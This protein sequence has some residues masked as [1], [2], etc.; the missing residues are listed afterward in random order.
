MSANLIALSSI[1]RP[2]QPTPWTALNDGIVI[3]KDILELLSSSMYVDPMS[4]YREYVQN[5]ADSTDQARAL[6]V[7]D[8]RAAARVEIE[9][10]ASKRSIRIRD[11]GLGV[12][13]AEF[14]QRLVAFGASTKR[15]QRA[16]GFRGVGRLAGL[17]YC[18][19]L[20]FRG[21]SQGDPIVFEMLWDCRK[22]RALL[23]AADSNHHLREV[24]MQTVSTR[25]VET[26]RVP[27]HFFE[28]EMCGV[29]RH[30]N[31]QLLDPDAVTSYLSQVAPVPF[32]PEFS[33][34]DDIC[35]TLKAYVKLGE[36]RIAI[37][38]AE[39]PVYRPHR[40]TIP[41]SAGVEERFQAWEPVSV[42][43]QDGGM[44]AIGWV[45]HHSY[46]G[47]LASATGIKGLRVRC[48]NIQVGDDRV[49][50]EL[51]LE[52]RFNSWTVGEIHVI[53]PRILPNGRRDHFEQNAHYQNLLTHLTPLAREL[54]RRCRTSSIKRN[55]WREFLRQLE[56]TRQDLAIIKQGAISRVEVRRLTREVRAQVLEL[57]RIMARGV[58]DPHDKAEAERELQKLKREVLKLSETGRSAPVLANFPKPQRQVFAKVFSLIYECAPNRIVAKSLVDRIMA[59]LGAKE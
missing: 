33:H 20:L 29:I 57:K 18:Q 59:R 7:M 17:G 30:R 23:R 26:A 55:R 34:R 45:L 14:V 21:R 6:G 27:G 15:G 38:G 54:S 3:G 48:G 53:D 52:P 47:A 2:G 19:E 25:S 46:A 43:A 35:N 49:F 10:D 39:T 12:P 28:V 42:P 41:L 44:A 40:N 51:F 24:V 9:I 13:R 37:N 58:F 16:R 32:S 4:I 22:L 31:D 1:G 5:A 50:E 8:E 36:L 11:N 56:T